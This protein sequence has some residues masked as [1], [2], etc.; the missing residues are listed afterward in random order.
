MC[1]SGE[2]GIRAASAHVCRRSENELSTVSGGSEFET[3]GSGCEQRPDRYLPAV[4]SSARATPSRDYE[5]RLSRT[6]WYHDWPP[7]LLPN[8]GYLDTQFTTSE[9]SDNTTVFLS[10]VHYSSNDRRPC[11]RCPLSS[12]LGKPFDV[13]ETLI[14]YLDYYA[15][16]VVRHSPLTLASIVSVVYICF[17]NHRTCSNAR[18]PME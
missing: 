14:D 8:L 18:R 11:N 6:C 5:L 1:D 2:M 3:D 10:C 4:R 16:V 17:I 12:Y 15:I 7:R 13:G 9:T